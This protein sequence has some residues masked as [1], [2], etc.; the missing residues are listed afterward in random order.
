[1]S[2]IVMLLLVLPEPPSGSAVQDASSQGARARGSVLGRAVGPLRALRSKAG[3]LVEEADHLVE[4]RG[5][6]DA[7]AQRMASL[8][9]RLAARV[10]QHVTL[11]A[12]LLGG[13]AGGLADGSFVTGPSSVHMERMGQQLATVS[14]QVSALVTIMLAQRMKAP[15]PVAEL[16]PG[17]LA[18]SPTPVPAPAPPPPVVSSQ[19]RHGKEE[20]PERSKPLQELKNDM[21]HVSQQSDDRAA[22]I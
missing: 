5:S 4:S 21:W 12:Q 17:M 13:R 18:M 2:V 14:A 6:E 3:H 10:A 19:Y 9:A 7:A 8:E 11:Q 20:G 16:A 1:M 22:A 15:A